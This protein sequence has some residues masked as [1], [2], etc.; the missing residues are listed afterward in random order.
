VSYFNRKK[1]FNF[2]NP[3]ILETTRKEKTVTFK[4][5]YIW[6]IFIV[7]LFGLI[8]WWIFYSQFFKIKNIEISGTVNDSIKK[9][10]D[11][12]KGKN[13][14]LFVVGQKDKELASRQSSIEKIN[15]V[16]G[17]PDTLKVEVLVRK[18]IIRWKSKDAIYFID[19]KGIAFNL[20]SPTDG[21]NKLPL[22]S[23]SRNLDV[24]VGG[25]IVT[26]EFVDFVN[27]LAVKIPEKIKKEVA[28]YIVDETTLHLEVKFR[29]SYKV[30]FDT[31][32]NLDDQ[33]YL[34]AKIIEKHDSEITDYVDL[35]VEGR[36][37]YK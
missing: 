10:I 35:R 3:K 5:A 7:A 26:K 19:E 34:L 21:D 33:I 18:P 11:S 15:I 37:Y 14:F 8:A 36:A 2:R 28:E 30:F 24:K 22:V 27:D 12:F 20:E 16:K 31:T 23:D 13:I 32:A 1:Q 17:I 25:R 6:F 29:D 9:E 4:S